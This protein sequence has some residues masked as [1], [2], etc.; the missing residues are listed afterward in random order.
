MKRPNQ[1]NVRYFQNCDSHT[2][3]YLLGF[4]AADG[5]LQS[6][7]A[8]GSLGLTLTISESDIQ[9]L[10]KLK[11]EIGCENRIYEIRGKMTHDKTKEKYHCRFQLFNKL[12][13]SD[14][15]SYG[16]TPRKSITM[17]NIVENIP[18]EY[19]KSFILG[20]FDG[21]GSVTK[22]PKRTQ[23]M[24]SFR[25]TKEFL[26]GIA[27]ELNLE[28]KWLYKDKQKNCYSLVFWRKADLTS[29]LQ[30]YNNLD[31][32]LTRKYER[33]SDFLKIDKDETISPS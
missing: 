32:Y 31:F 33:F 24:V 1:G 25:G 29:F 4:I 13:Y 26:N 10:E 8:S 17:P 7:G 18:Q 30:I 22:N 28:S 14:L 19:R 2:K 27:T 21:D 5:C 9:I 11:Q 12:L 6:N 16:L 3:A 23:L 20:Y 15:L